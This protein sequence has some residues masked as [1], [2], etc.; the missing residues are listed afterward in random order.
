[1]RVSEPGCCLECLND[2]LFPEAL[3]DTLEASAMIDEACVSSKTRGQ[4]NESGLVTL[5][6]LTAG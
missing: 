5:H 3:A 6:V 2:A 1:M 4:C